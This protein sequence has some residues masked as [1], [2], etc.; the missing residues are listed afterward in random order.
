MSDRTHAQGRRNT[1]ARRPSTVERPTSRTQ[2]MRMGINV[3]L[4]SDNATYRRTGVS[5]Y[6]SE[7]V[8]AMQVAMPTGDS[9]IRLGSGH[10]RLRNGRCPNCLGADSP[11]RS[12]TRA[13]TRRTAQPGECGPPDV[14]R[15]ERRYRS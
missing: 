4:V 1:L 2:Q 5:R 11:G 3:S 14:A 12:R 7:L 13:A 8:S 9:L 10:N 15:P 6:I